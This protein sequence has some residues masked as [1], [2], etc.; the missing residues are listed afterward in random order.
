MGR[1]TRFTGAAFAVWACGGCIHRRR[2]AGNSL[3]RR[4][5]HR[6]ARPFII[7]III[8]NYYYYYYYL[9]ALSENQ[10]ILSRVIRVFSA[11]LGLAGIDAEYQTR[12]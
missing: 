3:I 4:C 12:I 9:F 7:I 11:V 10:S 1:P 2:R 6:R 8:I 5:R